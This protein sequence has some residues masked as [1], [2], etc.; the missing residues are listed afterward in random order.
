MNPLLKIF[1]II[2]LGYFLYTSFFSVKEGVT[3]TN[4]DNY[5]TFNKKPWDDFC[6]PNSPSCEND[7]IN[8]PKTNGTTLPGAAEPGCHCKKTGQS[9]LTRN[10]TDIDYNPFVEYRR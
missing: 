8:A 4:Y 1:L 7:P 9:T 6:I 2:V 10:C 5:H 3:F